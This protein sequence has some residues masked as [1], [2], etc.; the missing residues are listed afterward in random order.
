MRDAS[1][2]Q[3]RVAEEGGAVPLIAAGIMVLSC[4]LCL[5]TVDLG[6]AVLAR[7][8]AQT[9]ADAAVLA[10]AQEIA[11]PRGTQPIDVARRFADL[12]GA[13]LVT[14]RCD[15][16]ATEAV[17]SVQLSVSFVLLGPDRTVTANARAVI[18]PP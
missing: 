7:G 10:A 4:V 3:R 12:N 16:G 5:V 9:A 2:S 13:M 8:R 15:A 14:C 1:R 11:I 17:V 6:R 18:G